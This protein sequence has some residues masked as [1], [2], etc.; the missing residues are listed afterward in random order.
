MTERE[1]I[2]ECQTWQ[3][4]I[5]V[6]Q[7]NNLYDI[8]DCIYDGYSA[9]EEVNSRMEECAREY[10]W[11][12]MRDSL[13]SIPEFYNDNYYLCNYW[14]GWT[15]LDDRDFESYKDDVLRAMEG[16][17]DEE[18]EETD[19]EYCDNSYDEGNVESEDEDLED[20]GFSILELMSVCNSK[21]KEIKSEEDEEHLQEIL[22]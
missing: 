3:D 12:E 17:W 8:I 18:E 22:F 10:T 20:E 4:L 6:C 16:L 19:E 7:D 11:Q 1:F 15:E 5:D 2:E 13:N 21:L 9:D 14:D